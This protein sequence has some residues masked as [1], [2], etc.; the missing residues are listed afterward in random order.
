MN[1][2]STAP[3]V[4]ARVA[5]ECRDVW[6]IFGETPE[7]A[8]AALRAEGLGKSEVLRRWNCVVGVAGVSFEV[9]S[10]EIFCVMG[11]SGSGKSTLVRHIN[12]LI[13]PTAGQILIDGQ[14]IAGKRGAELR[15]IRA[16]KIGM[17]FQNF[18]LLPHL[19]VI[20]NVALGL[21]LRKLPRDERVA[22]ARRKL[23]LV[24]LSE[25]GEAWPEELS[26][27]MQQRV[28][29]AR[30]LASDPDILLMD[31]PFSALDPLIRRQLQDLFIDLSRQ[32]RKTTVF[33][34][35]DLAEA[36]RIG[37][38]IG[39]MRDGRM[40]QIGTPSDIVN[41]PRDDYVKAFVQGI[42]R[43]TVLSAADI[44]EPAG[45]S[46]AALAAE[47]HWPE[48]R[49][50]ALLDELIDLTADSD[51]PILIRDCRGAPAGI[52]RRRILLRSI[53]GK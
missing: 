50:A 9:R 24:Q 8:L 11:L 53:Q 6:K 1:E 40:V 34:T 49:P 10:G 3:Q 39:I 45:N 7:Q 14:D 4:S 16:E 5:V 21:E 35:H 38:R 26:G 51:L 32:M 42:S 17:V 43:L 31:E 19:N 47:Q 44:M 46:D 2:L 22:T 25:W 30:A 48:S 28:G 37:H 13:Q 20:D 15:R 27:G 52:V 41:R 18:A 33:I 29:L 12:G 36:I 23:E